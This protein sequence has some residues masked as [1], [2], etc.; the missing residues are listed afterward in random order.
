[1]TKKKKRKC[2]KEERKQDLRCPG[3]ALLRTANWAHNSMGKAYHEK[4]L[5]AMGGNQSK[6]DSLF[7]NNRTP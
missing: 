3:V 4:D 7:F 5:H 6:T 1:M 2:A